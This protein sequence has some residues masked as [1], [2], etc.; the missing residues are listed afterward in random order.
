MIHY[1]ANKH[2][3]QVKDPNQAYVPGGMFIG[4]VIERRLENEEELADVQALIKKF[5]KRMVS[6][7]L[8]LD[9][10]GGVI[11]EEMIGKKGLAFAE[12]YFDQYWK[13]LEALFTGIYKNVYEI[14]PIWENYEKICKMLDEKFAMFS[15]TAEST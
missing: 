6:P 9:S 11:D 2:F 8:L 14:K 1:N 5:R 15:K 10:L 7:G 13:D 4:W 3:E 12:S